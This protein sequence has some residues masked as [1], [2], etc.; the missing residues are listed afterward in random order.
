MTKKKLQPGTSLV[1]QMVHVCS[2]RGYVGHFQTVG[3]GNG[4]GTSFCSEGGVRIQPEA[5]TPDPM[6]FRVREASLWTSLHCVWNPGLLKLRK[7]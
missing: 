5:N 4:R 1:L 6:G 2:L 3:K 7:G